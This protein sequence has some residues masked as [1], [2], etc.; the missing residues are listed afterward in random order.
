[1]NNY[2]SNCP[3][4]A[5]R[6]AWR[7]LFR[8][9]HVRPCMVRQLGW[10]LRRKVARKSNCKVRKGSK[11][12][13]SSGCRITWQG[14][15]AKRRVRRIVRALILGHDQQLG[16][17][18]RYRKMRTWRASTDVNKPEDAH[19]SSVAIERQRDIDGLRFGSCDRRRLVNER[20]QGR[21]REKRPV[22]LRPCLR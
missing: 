20:R 18:S 12:A 17:S 19:G 5:R 14:A 15:N 7:D 2:C 16:R 9:L 8:I 10:T 3:F 6:Q 13:N 11:Q 21:G 1:M 22:S 4:I